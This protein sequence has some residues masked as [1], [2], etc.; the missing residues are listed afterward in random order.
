LHANGAGFK[1]SLEREDGLSPQA[2]TGVLESLAG[3]KKQSWRQKKEMVPRPGW[4]RER[5][6]RLSPQRAR[7]IS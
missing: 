2:P 4:G 1:R 6:K 7:T 3:G 5:G